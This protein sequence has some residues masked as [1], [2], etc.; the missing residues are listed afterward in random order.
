MI[1]KIHNGRNLDS[2]FILVGHST[3]DYSNTLIPSMPGETKHCTVCHATDAWKDVPVRTNMQTWMVVCTSCHDTPA[4]AVHV[5]LNT[6][7]GALGT[8]ACDV[9]HGDGAAFSVERVHL[10]H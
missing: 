5:R 4:T 3:H 7:A 9:C 1:H 2:I 8:E 10:V 6:V